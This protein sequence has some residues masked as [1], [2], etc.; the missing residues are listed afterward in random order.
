MQKK[1]S[2]KKKKEQAKAERERTEQ[3]LIDEERRRKEQDEFAA[4]TWKLLGKGK[5]VYLNKGGFF[6]GV[7]F[8]DMS[9]E[10][11]LDADTVDVAANWDEAT[12]ASFNPGIS[13]V[14]YNQKRWVIAKHSKTSQNVVMGIKDP[15]F[16]RPEDEARVMDASMLP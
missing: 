7:G 12:R 14:L 5:D 6:Q 11:F 2:E 9:E 15:M 10:D 8:L 13:F 1:A 4:S 3:E 16:V